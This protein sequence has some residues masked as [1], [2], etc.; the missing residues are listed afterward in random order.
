MTE[1]QELHDILMNKRYQPQRDWIKLEYSR[2]IKDESDLP[3]H[4]KTERGSSKG[5]SELKQRLSPKLIF[6]MKNA[7]QAVQFQKH[8]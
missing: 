5:D 1:D 3:Q 4:D 8:N 6:I 2:C 7:V